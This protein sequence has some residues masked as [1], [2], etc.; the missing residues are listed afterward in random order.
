MEAFRLS[1]HGIKAFSLALG[2]WQAELLVRLILKLGVTEADLV[3]ATPG[4]PASTKIGGYF[5]RKLFGSFG[6]AAAVVIADK[7]KE[8]MRWPPAVPPQWTVRMGG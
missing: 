4:R 5:L 2:G 7:L 3:P 1:N 8:D 6:D